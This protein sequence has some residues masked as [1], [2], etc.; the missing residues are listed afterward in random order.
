ME[1]FKN[2]VLGNAIGGLIGAGV[3]YVIFAF[4]N[5]INDGFSSASQAWVPNHTLF[6]IVNSKCPDNWDNVGQLLLDAGP[7]DKR[8][9]ENSLSK[10]YDGDKVRQI[11]AKLDK[12]DRDVDGDVLTWDSIVVTACLKN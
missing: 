10:S 5:N 12:D 3:M 8:L 4:G 9:Y 1:W 11:M 7:G 2:N 6:M